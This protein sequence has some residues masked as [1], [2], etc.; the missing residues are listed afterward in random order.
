M[1]SQPSES[2]RCILMSIKDNM[3]LITPLSSTFNVSK[4]SIQFADHSL[5]HVNALTILWG[6]W[7]ECGSNWCRRSSHAK[8]VTRLRFCHLE[9]FLC[10]LLW[11]YLNQ[12]TSYSNMLHDRERCFLSCHEGGT[13]KKFWAAPRN[14]TSDGRIPRFNALPLSHRESTVSEVYYEVHMTR[15]LHTARISNVDSV[16]FVDRNKRDG[17]FW[18]R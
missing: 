10:Q 4:Y 18:A 11:Y 13:K 6:M 16:L 15:V 9:S 8:R 5:K 14:Q 7:Y 1:I 12:Q 2:I 3:V 17:K